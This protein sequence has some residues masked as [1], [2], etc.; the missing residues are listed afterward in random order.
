MEKIEQ[1]RIL[2]HQVNYINSTGDKIDV[3][4]IEEQIEL[5]DKEGTLYWDGYIIPIG[6]WWVEQEKNEEV[7]KLEDANYK[8]GEEISALSNQLLQWQEIATALYNALGKFYVNGNAESW[9][10]RT[11]A[12]EKYEQLIKQQNN[13]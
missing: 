7:K 13:G 8:L 9:E 12:M 3:A 4:Q 5:G 11:I 1:L 6:R 10:Q 2:G